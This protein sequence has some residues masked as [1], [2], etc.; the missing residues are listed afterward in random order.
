MFRAETL[1]IRLKGAG[2]HANLMGYYFLSTNVKMQTAQ[3]NSGDL[4]LKMTINDG[5]F[6][7]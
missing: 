4:L 6:S 2:F 7:K 3:A 1:S 5:S